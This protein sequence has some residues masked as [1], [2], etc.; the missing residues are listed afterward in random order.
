MADRMEELRRDGTHSAR[1]VRVNVSESSSKPNRYHRLRDQLWW[2]VGRQLTTT[3][4][5]DLSQIN[6]ATVAQLTSPKYAM[7]SSGRIKVEAKAD[8]KARL[9]RSPDDADALL[10]AF[11]QG[12]G[13]GA[14]FLD[15]WR[16]HPLAEGNVAEV[17]AKLDEQAPKRQLGRRMRSG[18]RFG[19]GDPQ[20]DAR[21]QHRWRGPVCVFC[22]G[23]RPE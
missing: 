16:T 18:V 15:M 20:L 21:C 19:G 13:Q 5:W 23:R 17:R 3:G 1:V 22:Q 9:G 8:T 7:D 2:E 12:R 4:G 10:L 14:A 6:D 11:Y